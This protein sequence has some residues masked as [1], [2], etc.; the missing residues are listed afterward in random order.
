[1]SEATFDRSLLLPDALSDWYRARPFQIAFAL[2]VV[3]H[4]ALIAFVPGFRPP[5]AEP[6]PVLNVQIVQPEEPLATPRPRQAVAPPVRPELAPVAPQPRALEQPLVRPQVE[7]LPVPLQPLQEPQPQEPVAR[8]E[9]APPVPVQRPQP[10]VQPQPR[11]APEQPALP[12]IERQPLAELDR[13]AL[14]LPPSARVDPK[15]QAE[16]LIRPEPVPA[17]PVHTPRLESPPPPPVAQPQIAPP[18][19]A[20]AEP[21]P[22]APVQ[23]PVQAAPP[24]QAAPQPQIAP[25]PVAVVQP[26]DRS[27]TAED[28]A[29]LRALTATF[30]QQVSSRIKRYQRY[31]VVAQ[32][33]GWEG[34]AEVL[35]RFGAD[36][37]VSNIVLGKSTGRE[38]LDEEA[39]NMVRRATPLPEAPEGLF[40]REIKVPIVFRLQDS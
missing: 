10:Q 20:R 29:S 19:V 23:P 14:A 38:V 35:V 15:P 34:T 2:S 40:G 9:L 36:G 7:P 27:S 12:L 33:R 28:A 18:P 30:S 37:K 8:A 21:R 32:R 6:Q 17:P 1:M 39:V 13:P 22:Q 25:P 11:P 24:A 4:A 26:P 31:P 5:I 16:P 3:V